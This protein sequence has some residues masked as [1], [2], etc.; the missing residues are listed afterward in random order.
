MASP[1]RGGAR[2]IPAAGIG[3]RSPH[4]THVLSHRPSAGWFEVHS[5]NFFGL[6]G[7]EGGR[8]LAILLE[9]RPDY[10]LSLHGVSMSLGSA[11][12]LDKAYL[13]RLRRL[14]DKVDP[15]RVSDHLC[16]T[17]IDGTQLHDLL[18]LPYTEEALRHVC[19]RIGQA[20]EALGRRLLVENVSSYLEFTHSEMTEWEFLSEISRRSGCAILLDVNNIYVSSRNHGFDPREYLEGI[21]VEAVEQFHLAGYSDNGDHLIDTH[22]HPVSRPVWDLF[23]E[24]VARFGPV[25]TLIEWDDRLPS[26]ER[27]QKEADRAERI[28]KQV[29][30]RGGARSSPRG[31]ATLAGLDLPG[32]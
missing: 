28:Q 20:Q 26:F 10:P 9:L 2:P 15:V 11:D 12:P 27:L 32:A 18:P 5:E 8:P 31:A 29:L 21:P 16:W 7:E 13:K 4:Y 22:D 25:P 1:S 23:S 17:R 6:G 19:R 30:A 14:V 3:L 24:A